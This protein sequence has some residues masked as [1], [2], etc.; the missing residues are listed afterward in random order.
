MGALLG[1]DGEDED[2]LAAVERHLEAK[3]RRGEKEIH[4][5]TGVED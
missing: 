4:K 2:E 1:E 5:N 3:R